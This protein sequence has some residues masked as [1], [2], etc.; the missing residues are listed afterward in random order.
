MSLFLS[1]GSQLISPIEV[2][3]KTLTGEIERLKAESKGVSAFGFKEGKITSFTP[4][5]LGK[6]LSVEIRHIYTGKFPQSIFGFDESKSLLV[7]S[8]H[9]PITQFSSASRAV[10]LLADD[11]KP[12]NGI[13]T[14]SA[15]SQGTPIIYY[16]PAFVDQSISVTVELGFE[17]FSKKITDFLSSAFTQAAS[18]PLFATKSM[19]LIAGGMITQLLGDLGKAIFEKGPEMTSTDAINFER[20]GMGDTA[21]GFGVLFPDDTPDFVC[22][23]YKISEEG[24]LI[25]RQTGQSYSEGYPYVIVS[26]DGKQ[27]TAYEKFQQTAA[28]SELLARFYNLGESSA[29]PIDQLLEGL[30]Y[31]NDMA[32]RRKAEELKAKMCDSS[33]TE[34]ELNKLSTMHKAL[35]DNI[36][37]KELKPS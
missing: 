30:K 12:H 13:D 32:Y 22:K 21:A 36:L 6:P 25:D 19:H 37:T 9:K 35:I 3:E 31:Y 18:I 7:T 23:K 28:S 15:L 4:V 33:I 1:V 10:N 17:N 34:E 14:I 24:E 26:I 5:G 20:P 11:V 27:N 2:P 16:S 8:S 29:K